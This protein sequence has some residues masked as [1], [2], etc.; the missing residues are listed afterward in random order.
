[1]LS[2][3]F[4]AAIFFGAMVG[5]VLWIYT[6]IK[7]KMARQRLS[8]L[9]ETQ[10][11]ILKIIM[12]TGIVLILGGWAKGLFSQDSGG[13]MLL[14]F[15]ILLVIVSWIVGIW[16][17]ISAEKQKQK[18]LQE[19]QL[20]KEQEA[21]AQMEE[22]NAHLA[23]VE[24]ER[25]ARMEAYHEE[26]QREIEAERLAREQ[27][28]SLLSSI[29]RYEITINP[30]AVKQN[31]NVSDFYPEYSPLRKNMNLSRVSSF[32]VIDTETTG[33]V[34]GRDKIVQISAIRFEGFEPT[35][36]FTTYIN[37]DCSIPPEAT[38]IHGITDD[39][40]ADSPKFEYILNSLEE[41]L[42]ASTLVGHNL[43]FDLRFLR[44]FG[45]D[46]LKV[47]RSYFDTLTLSRTY[48]EI[49]EHKLER[50][51][52]EH[53]IYYTAHDSAEDALASGLLFIEYLKM[54]VG[55]LF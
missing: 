35:E 32:V 26:I 8:V 1:M 53:G 25:Q 47:N 43:Q 22:E 28:K 36:I 37:P 49:A 27:F 11:T 9:Q 34:P 52:H 38:K 54:K 39:M 23:K 29:P 14:L 50:A 42:G 17:T 31:I 3:I 21:Q 24:A 10:K 30:S 4:M 44:K 40:V 16:L 51:C 41:F 45:Y 18:E 46:S 48:D 13:T 55:D 7:N 33:L 19:L 12:W 2:H 20:K 5:I 15:G 6:M